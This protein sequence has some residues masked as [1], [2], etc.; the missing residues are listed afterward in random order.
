MVDRSGGATALLGMEGFVVLAM[1][2]HEDEWWLLVETTADQVGCQDCGVRGLATVAQLS[3]CA[4]CRSATRRF[5]SCGAS[6]A[7]AVE[8][9][10]VRS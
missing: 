7:G 2:E 8:T 10:T 9:R 4:I 3:R 5:A 1:D 6:V